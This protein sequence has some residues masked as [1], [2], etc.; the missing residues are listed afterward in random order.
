MKRIVYILL[1]CSIGPVASA[2]RY[3]KVLNGDTI[4]CIDNQGVRQGLWKNLDS[5]GKYI[6]DE[7]MYVDGRKDGVWY[8]YY[9]NGK[10]K[11]SVTFRNGVPEGK[12]TSYYATGQMSEQGN[13]IG[14]SWIGEYTI[15]YV[16][17]CLL[18]RMVY[19]KEGFRVSAVYYSKDSCGA[20]A[21]RQGK[22]KRSY[23]R[24]LPRRIDYELEY[25]SREFL[26]M[27]AQ[28]KEHFNKTLKEEKKP[29]MR[30]N[31]TPKTFNPEPH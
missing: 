3:C 10:V 18:S 29:R 19:D 14:G 26:V 11:F 15:Y 23:S 5:R 27:E 9:P 21:K 8:D 31:D 12:V 30:E 25:A 7:G 4:N 24:I 20:V 1:F 16:N 6:L 17:G 28:K 2:Q 13:W 22:V